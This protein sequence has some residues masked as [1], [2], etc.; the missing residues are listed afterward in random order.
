MTLLSDILK[1]K[2]SSPSIRATRN[3][4]LWISDPRFPIQNYSCTSRFFSIFAARSWH[5]FRITLLAMSLGV[6]RTAHHLSRTTD[7]GESS[8]SG[9]K[10]FAFHVAGHVPR[11][12]RMFMGH[13][14]SSSESIIPRKVC[15]LEVSEPYVCEQDTLPAARSLARLE[16][17]VQVSRFASDHK[18][19]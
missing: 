12:R 4:M 19:R 7:A 1:T 9:G 10:C 3:S 8:A 13:A 18:D 17:P 2:S 15:C 11:Q 6:L 16:T 5:W 14:S